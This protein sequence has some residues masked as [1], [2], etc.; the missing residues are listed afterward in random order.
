MQ[1][2]YFLVPTG[3]VAERRYKD[4]ICK[5][6]L[7]YSS[8]VYEAVCSPDLI[9]AGAASVVK[10]KLEQE[11]DKLKQ[12]VDADDIQ[13]IALV[14]DYISLCNVYPMAIIYSECDV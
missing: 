4:T 10:Q 13:L 5:S 6:I 8:I 2:V 3:I 9:G 11:L 12:L 7:R 14:E 1:V